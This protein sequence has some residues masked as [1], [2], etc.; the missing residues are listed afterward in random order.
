MSNVTQAKPSPRW[1]TLQWV[2]YAWRVAESILLIVVLILVLQQL[3][4]LTD[5]QSF[6]HAQASAQLKAATRAPGEVR[7]LVNGIEQAVETNVDRHIDSIVAAEQR[8]SA[9]AERRIVLAVE[10]SIERNVD[11]HLVRLL[12]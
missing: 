4:K 9:G 2:G 10:R 3:S 11:R 1:V 12:K 6:D 7:T 5:V 8:G